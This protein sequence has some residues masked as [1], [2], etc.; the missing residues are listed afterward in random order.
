MKIII[1]E[2]TD[3]EVKWDILLDKI[4]NNLEQKIPVFIGTKK[5]VKELKEELSK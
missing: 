3:S 2:R 4:R 5:Q 1:Y